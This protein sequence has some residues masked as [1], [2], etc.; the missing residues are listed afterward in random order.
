MICTFLFREGEKLLYRNV[1]RFRD[2]L[3]FEAHKLL[4]H[5]TL[6]LR[7]IKKKEG[8]HVRLFR[9]ENIKATVFALGRERARESERVS[10]R[11]RDS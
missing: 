5:R 1:K 7:V 4:H 10:E 11:E 6:G 3:V 2:G 8:A 9:I